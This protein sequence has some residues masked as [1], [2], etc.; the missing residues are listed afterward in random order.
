MRTLLLGSSGFIGS[1]T[2][3]AC[4]EGGAEVFGLSRSGGAGDHPDCKSL[5]GDR[6]DVARVTD[7]IA[8]FKIDTI[9]D[10]RAM[11]LETTASLV[12]ALSAT[13]TRYVL[14]SSSDVYRNYGMLHKLET[15]APDTKVF[16]E[17]AT[18]RSVLY[19]YRTQATADAAAPDHWK[20]HYDKI[21]IEQFVARHHPNWTIL[22][23]PM[24][25]GL[26][27][28][29]GRF[30]WALRPMLKGAPVLKVPKPWLDWTTTYGFV[31]NVG[32]A[33]ASAA[34]SDNARGEIFNIGDFDPMPH[35][36]WITLLAKVT[37]WTGEVQ[38]DD[39]PASPFAQALSGLDLRVPLAMSCHKLRSHLG[40]VPSVDLET[41]LEGLI[42]PIL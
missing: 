28:K 31:D 19:P 12:T 7:I 24:V 23:L 11:S 30:D 29:T 9:V 14:I 18:L 6:E 1:A 13:D 2:Q 34:R 38:V 10:F 5:S 32:D 15:G 26:G 27:D 36:E 16:E 8:Q 39:D 37:G 33:I 3:N 35:S 21:P 22:R 42:R 40:F 4:L 17:T 25:F 20:H 41:A